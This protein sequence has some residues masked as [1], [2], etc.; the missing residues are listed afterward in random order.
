MRY[1]LLRTTI[2]GRL[3]L[4]IGAASCIALVAAC[5]SRSVTSVPISV[6]PEAFNNG[7]IVASR[8]MAP[9]AVG[10]LGYTGLSSRPFAR[11]KRLLYACSYLGASVEVLKQKGENQQPIGE[12]TDGIN[13]ASSLFTDQQGNLYVGNWFGGNITVYPRG[14]I[15][16]SETLNGSDNPDS[17]VVGLDGTVYVANYSQGGSLGPGSVAKYPKGQTKP[18]T[19]LQFEP[20]EFPTGLALD[21]HNNLFIA[22]E[23][24]ASNGGVLEMKSGKSKAENIGIRRL[25]GAAGLAIDRNDNL[26]VVNQDLVFGSG[27]SKA[28]IYVYRPGQHS[29]SETILPPPN[30]LSRDFYNVALDLSNKEMWVS[31]VGHQILGMT[32]PGGAVIDEIDL[33]QESLSVGIATS[34][35][36]TN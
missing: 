2:L 19:I 15:L 7:P 13:G 16:P 33:K 29:P 8:Q 10:A 31:T 14:S 24:G 20:N 9:A 18:K 12:I 25:T 3:P 30:D 17:L 6:P 4:S 5:S 21:S 1:P 36:G 27:P 28:A 26:L 22:F 23:K 32:Y 35:A 11:S 34:P